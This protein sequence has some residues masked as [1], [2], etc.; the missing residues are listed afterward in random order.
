MVWAFIYGL[1]KGDPQKLITLYDYDANGCGY[2]DSVKS[3]DY[4]YWVKIDYRSY[5]EY[6]VCVKFCP[7]IVNPLTS[8]DCYTNSLVTY[9]TTGGGDSHDSYD[10]KKYLNRFCLPDTSS[11]NADATY[12]SAKDS[13]L[14]DFNAEWVTQYMG[15]LAICWWVCIVCTAVAFVFGIIYMIFIRC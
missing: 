3:F 6:S 13:A 7:T 1:A 4:I 12:S 2:T 8:A 15:D 5:S 9:C 14:S 10:S 11:V